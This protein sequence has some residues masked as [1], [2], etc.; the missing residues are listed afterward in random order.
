[1]TSWTLAMTPVLMIALLFLFVST[2]L[3]VLK[4]SSS[5]EFGVYLVGAGSP[6]KIE[7]DSLFYP[8]ESD[9]TVKEPST[10]STSLVEI[11]SIRTFSPTK[12]SDFFSNFLV[13]PPRGS[14]SF[15]L[16][17]QKINFKLSPRLF[18]TTLPRL[19]VSSASLVDPEHFEP[20]IFA[21]ISDEREIPQI[22]SEEF[23]ESNPSVEFLFHQRDTFTGYHN[24]A[25]STKIALINPT[26]PFKSKTVSKI[27]HVIAGDFVLK[28]FFVAVSVLNRSDGLCD[29][30]VFT[31][32][33]RDDYETVDRI[34]HAFS[35][36]RSLQT[37]RPAPAVDLVKFRLNLLQELFKKSLKI[38]GSPESSRKNLRWTRYSALL[39]ILPNSPRSSPVRRTTPSHPKQQATVKCPLSI[40]NPKDLEEGSEDF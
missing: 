4:V 33:E 11:P 6:S 32:I 8:I 15:R 2:L 19:L 21:E 26:C 29:L 30:I 31:Q 10:S 40:I 20:V 5:S 3:F 7:A 27:I 1:M 9:N 12:F 14:P 25:A 39:G 22:L 37:F 28:Q 13:S 38:T 16:S 23:V 34:L 24:Y 17:P 18:E 36:Y 35:R